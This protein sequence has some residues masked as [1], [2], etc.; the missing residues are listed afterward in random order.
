MTFMNDIKYQMTY[1]VIVA[2]RLLK[3]ICKAPSKY[4]PTHNNPTEYGI[5]FVDEESISERLET[6]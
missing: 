1:V 5:S 3:S 6:G 2:K 4:N